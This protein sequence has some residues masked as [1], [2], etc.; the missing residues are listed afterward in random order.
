MELKHEPLPKNWREKLNNKDQK[1]MN[2]LIGHK[3]HT[4][5]FRGMY[6]VK[7]VS[8]NKLCITCKRWEG[9]EEWIDNSS[10]I[11]IAGGIHSFKS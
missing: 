11:K 7:R 9:R 2:H 5:S 10:F 1:W 3:I 4:W 6:T 8:E